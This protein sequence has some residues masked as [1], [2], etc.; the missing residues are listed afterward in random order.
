MPPRLVQNEASWLAFSDLVFVDPVGTGFS[1]VIEKDK[2]K[3]GDEKE[4]KDDALDPKEF[5]G[6]KRDLES[7]CEFMGRWL[8]GNGRWGSPVFIAGESYG[9]YRVGRL[10]RMLQESTGV[11]L[12]GA[13]LIS[14]WLEISPLN[15]TGND[16]LGWI[17]RLP[18]MAAAAVHH[19]RS[20]AFAHGTALDEV[21]RDA[22]AFATG[23]Y[24][25]FLTRVAS[26]PSRSATASSPGSPTCSACRST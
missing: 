21:L 11:G 3:G 25:S 6:E 8:S 9:G 15:S 20:R 10:A 24:A 19:G 16:V 17:D 12:N 4:K 1:R 13:I 18:T 26:M 5:F 22:E 2:D 14:P 23:D 7:M